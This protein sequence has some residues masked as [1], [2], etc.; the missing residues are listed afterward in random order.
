VVAGIGV[1]VNIGE[2][3]L[4]VEVETAATSLLIE[5]GRE[6][7]RADL[8]VELLVRLETRYDAWLRPSG[9]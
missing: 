1:N 9:E 8:L 4:P 6:I 3:E 2:A 7:D 5:T